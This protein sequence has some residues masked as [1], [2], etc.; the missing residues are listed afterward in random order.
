[1]TK[2]LY[3]PGADRTSQWFGG[4]WDGVHVPDLDK[5]LLHST[6]TTGWPGYNGNGS[7]A[8]TATLNPWTRKIRQHFILPESARA[9][10]NPDSTAVSENKDEVCQ[11]E[12]IGYSDSAV[13]RRIGRTDRDL[14]NLTDGDLRWLASIIVFVMKEW[15]VPNV[16]ATPFPWPRYPASYG[17]NTTSRM[18]SSEYDKFSGVLGHLHAS[19]NTHGDPKLDVVKLKKFVTE[20]LAPA[21]TPTPAPVVTGQE[22]PDMQFFQI[23]GHADPKVAAAVIATDGWRMRWVNN[24]TT[25]ARFKAG[26]KAQTGRDVGVPVGVKDFNNLGFEWHGPV[27][28]VSVPDTKF[29]LPANVKVVS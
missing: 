15:T 11:F 7:N 14:D 5:I 20:Q 3:L 18:T 17:L 23:T 1:M 6:E 2:A 13:A 28:P 19:G 21:P 27:P 29:P 12:I 22:I 8:P 10:M 25:F 16:W 4:I 24:A 26:I 9:L